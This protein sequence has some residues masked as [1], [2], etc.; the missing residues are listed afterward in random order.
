MD[1]LISFEEGRLIIRNGERS[2]MAY[3]ILLLFVW[4]K[5]IFTRCL[6]GIM[7]TVVNNDSFIEN[8]IN[9]VIIFLIAFSIGVFRENVKKRDLLL[10]IGMAAVY[11]ISGFLHPANQVYL[12]EKENIYLILLQNLPLVLLGISLKEKYIDR[13]CSISVLSVYIFF[14]FAFVFHKLSL[15]NDG[16]DMGAAYSLL[17]HVLLIMVYTFR[18][19]SVFRV[20]TVIVS[21]II[22]VGIGSRGP[23]ACVLVTLSFVLV[24]NRKSLKERL[25]TMLLV[26]PFAIIIYVNFYNI[27]E[28]LVA[29]FDSFGLSS[30]VI[31]ALLHA[32]ITNDSGRS[33][34]SELFMRKLENDPGGYG[35]GYDRLFHVEYSHNIRLELMLSFGVISGNIIFAVFSALFVYAVLFE[36]RQANRMLIES[37]FF[38]TGYVKLFLSSS[39]LLEPGFFLLMGLSISAIRN[40]LENY[41]IERDKPFFYAGTQ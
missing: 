1:K 36:K 28:W 39:Y 14:L 9:I 21:L 20:I 4:S 34:I 8:F 33:N 2:E 5:T 26:V 40:N 32:E 29:V 6:E 12:F 10:C 25:I 19:P 13:M 31:N 18:K 35:I 17:M 38:G 15:T 11:I 16:S 24:E 7:R 27:V 3:T 41:R 37:L 22:L 23:I 30:R